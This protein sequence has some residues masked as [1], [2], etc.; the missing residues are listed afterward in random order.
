MARFLC[1]LALG[2][3]FLIVICI[4]SWFG[5]ARQIVGLHRNG[6]RVFILVGVLPLVTYALTAF[7]FDSISPRRRR[8]GIYRSKT[9]VFTAGVIVLLWYFLTSAGLSFASNWLRDEYLVILASL[10]SFLTVAPFTIK[11]LPGECRSCGYDITR[12]VAY[13]RCPECGVAGMPI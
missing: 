9:N 11:A 2:H 4:S 12:S 1:S 13:G 6:A 5:H 8:R 3:A 10:L 7:I